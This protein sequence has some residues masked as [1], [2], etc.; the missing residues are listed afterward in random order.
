[1]AD[2]AIEVLVIGIGP[3]DPELVTIKAI[4]A[5]NSADL[6]LI[7]RKGD[8]KA[9]LADL[10]REV[11][12]R[13]L[14]NPATRQVEFDLP[15]RDEK[16]SGGYLPSVNDWHDAIAGVYARL[17][18]TELPQGGRVA[19]L[20]WGDPSLYDSTLR[21]LSRLPVAHGLEI[22]IEVV[23]GITSLQ[24]LTARHHIPLNSLGG[25]V[26][27]TTGR[28]LREEGVPEE[29]D[30]VAV[31]LDRE[32]SFRVVP[33]DGFEIYWGAYLGLDHEIAASGELAGQAD[34]IAATRQAARAEHGWIMDL[35]I[36]RRRGRT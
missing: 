9:D 14:D 8:D 27:L 30:T 17:L 25:S 3:G 1:M 20:V 6:V 15:V 29:I 18:R 4:R 16:R 24:A 12:R 5:L 13:Y 36:L 19:L 32:A 2:P 11:C 10:R 22:E 7:P 26:L 35:Y 33:P 31:M 21:I 34:Q 28:R 23:P